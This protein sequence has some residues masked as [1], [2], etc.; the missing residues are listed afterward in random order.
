MINIL[1][2]FLTNKIIEN[3]ITKHGDQDMHLG[4]MGFCGYMLRLITIYVIITYQTTQYKSEIL[5]SIRFVTH[6][7]T[8]NDIFLK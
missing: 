7:Y 8:R 5:F 6:I 1:H 3:T 4:V 2:K